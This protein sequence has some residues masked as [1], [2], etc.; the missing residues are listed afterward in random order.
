MAKTNLDILLDDIT[1]NIEFLTDPRGCW[2]NIGDKE[3]FKEFKKSTKSTMRIIKF[4]LKEAVKREKEVVMEKEL[5][6]KGNCP[7]RVF[8]TE[9]QQMVSQF[10]T[11]VN[12][13]S[14]ENST[15][16]VR[17]YMI[18]KFDKMSIALYEKM[19]DALQI[20]NEYCK[21]EIPEVDL[22]TGEIIEA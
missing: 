12:I 1:D 15:N 4:L 5:P 18:V 6:L 21:E 2:T 7:A 11:A 22:E 13:I 3:G 14:D 9:Y 19:L 20:I 8:A 17:G 10:N 16:S